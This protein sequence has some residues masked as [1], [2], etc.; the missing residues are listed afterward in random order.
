SFQAS[1]TMNGKTWSLTNSSGIALNSSH[2][3]LEYSLQ[4][5][6]WSQSNFPAFH[7]VNFLSNFPGSV[8]IYELGF[9]YASQGNG[10]ENPTTIWDDEELILDYVSTKSNIRDYFTKKGFVTNSLPPSTSIVKEITGRFYYRDEDGSMLS[11]TI[12]VNAFQ[13]GFDGVIEA[14]TLWQPG[15]AAIVSGVLLIIKDNTVIVDVADSYE[16]ELTPAV[17]EILL[18]RLPF[19]FN[20]GLNGNAPIVFSG[21]SWD[22]GQKVIIKVKPDGIYAKLEV[23]GYQDFFGGET[24]AFRIEWKMK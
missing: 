9:G 8:E 12:P 2:S 18:S 21:Y 23:G 6:A 11:A 7:R 24:L 14:L 22:N 15:D 3:L 13:R 5:G 16:L 1:I 4:Q 19:P 20:I 10:Y 17:D